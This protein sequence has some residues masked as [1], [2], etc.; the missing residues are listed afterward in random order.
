MKTSNIPNSG[1]FLSFAVGIVYMWFGMLKFFPGVSPAETLAAETIGQLTF[2]LIPS[3]ISIQ[4]LATW[5]TGVGAML[6]LN[7][8]HRISIP[9]AL[10]H[11][12]LTFTPLFLLPELVFTGNPIFLTLPGQYIAKNIII[13]S[14]LAYLWKEYKLELRFP[15]IPIFSQKARS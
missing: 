4:L 9:L 12:T 14:V 15:K 5:E 8:L 6:I 11:I 3:Y 1:H 7:K 2:N 10:I 13:V